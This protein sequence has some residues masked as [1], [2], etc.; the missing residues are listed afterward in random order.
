MAK[1][2]PDDY[3]T[4]RQ[5][6]EMNG[7]LAPRAPATK[8]TM[9]EWVDDEGITRYKLISEQNKFGDDEKRIFIEE[10]AEHGRI[11]TAARKAG[12]TTTTAKKHVGKDPAF[13]ILVN[14][15]LEA[16]KDRLI[17]HHQ[18]LVFNGTQ[19]ITRDRDGNITGEEQIFPIRL[20]E[21]ELKKHDDGYRDKK[22]VTMNV[23]GGVLV[24]PAEVSMEEWESKF[25]SPKELTEI[26]DAE[27][28]DT[29][30]EDTTRE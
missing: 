6:R 9:V 18:N 26:V 5:M 12:V 15:A 2:N 29:I 28:V 19:K 8:L 16:Y 27:V 20:I 4:K 1:V 7:D 3:D 21:L 25:G 10:L 17:G 14:E 11:G 13:A 22:E 23:K 30:S 24:A